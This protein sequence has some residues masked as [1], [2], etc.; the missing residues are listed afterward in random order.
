MNQNKKQNHNSLDI[1][2]RKMRFSPEEVARFLGHKST[3][4]WSN[5]VQGQ[6]LPTLVNALRLGIILRVPVEFLFPSLYDSLRLQIRT[7]EE[8]HASEPV[9]QVLFDH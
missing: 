2:R 1:Y 5:Y 4:T 8:E 9:Q 3:T 7:E 6:R